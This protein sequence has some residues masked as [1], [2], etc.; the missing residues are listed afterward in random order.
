[1]EEE[2]E[3][4]QKVGQDTRAPRMATDQGD[5]STASGLLCPLELPQGRG[6]I[7]H[8][9]AFGGKTRHG[10]ATEADQG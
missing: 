4:G 6:R 10:N 1:M 5:R 8:P 3:G 7:P 2:S 9:G